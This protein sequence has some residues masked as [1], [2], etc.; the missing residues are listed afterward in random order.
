MTPEEIEE[1]INQ[2][3]AE[4][5]AAYEANR[6]TELADESQSQNRDDDDNENVKGNE[7]GNS[8]GNGD[9]NDGGNGNRNGGGNGNGNPNR[10]DRSVMP[11]AR[12]C[13]YHDFVKCQPLNFKGTEGVVELTRWFEKIETVFHIRNCPER[14]QVKYAT[15]TL[16]NSA[17]TWWNAH[18]R[19]IGANVAFSMSWRELMKLMTKR[20][21]ELTIMCTKMV[22]EEEDR[23]E[24]FI[25]G[26]PDNIQGN[27]IAVEPIRLQDVVCIANKLTD[28]KLKGYAVKNAKNK[29]RLDNN[30]KDNR[31]QQ[32]PYKRQNVGPCTV[33]C[34]K[35]N[36]VGHMARDCM[37][38]VA[39]TTTQRALVVNQRVPTCFECGRQGHYRNKCPKLKN[40]TCGNK[41]GKK[42]NEARGKAYVLGGG[43]ANPDSNVITSTFL[44]NNHYAS[45]LFDSGADRSFVSSTFSALLSVIPST[46]DVS[47]AVELADGRISET[48]TMLRGYTLGLLGHPFNIDLMPVELGSFDIIIGM[49]WLANHHVVIVCDEKIVRILYGDEVLIVQAPS[50]LQELSTQLQE[51]S[52]KGFIG[53]IKDWASPK[54]SMEIRQFL[55]LA[56]YY[57]RFIEGSENFMVYCDASH[58]GLG[59]VLIQRE[60][61]IAYASRQL[62]IHKKNYTTHDLELGVVVFALKMWRHYLHGTKILNAQAEVRKEENYVTKNLCRMIKKLEPS[63]EGTLCLRNRSWIPCYGDSRALIMHESHKSKYLIHPESN[64]MYQDLKNLYWWPN[65]KTEIATYVSTQ[66]DM[67]TANHLQTGGQSERTIQNLEDM[68]RACVNDFGR[69]WDRHLPLVE[70]RTTIVIKRV[71]KL[72]YSK[73]FTV[74]SVDHFSVGL[75]LEMLGNGY[76][77]KGQKESQKQQSQARDG[78]DKF[79]SKPKSVK[80]KSQP[81]EENT[82]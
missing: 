40:Q 21:Q 66:L 68:L 10:N 44:L 51:L 7:N 67:S 47:Y 52:D 12:E 57:R 81:S 29:R 53:L 71:S 23:F 22:P 1:H 24:K 60:K 56:G 73:N 19:K 55:G 58:K 33:K 25:G 42:T 39:A 5:L 30:H 11:V 62:K 46:L 13:T 27:V 8:G 74:V 75:R 34:G 36:K 79:K 65:M 6:V 4:A 38:V 31:V 2:R 43:E 32:P 35:C 26:L 48:N 82:T 41:A 69:S 77:R 17:L 16:L 45:M 49:D 72:H 78:K 9:G 15:C 76:S 63:A 14:Y 3:V 80:V 20:F 54:T 28:Q 50:E 64:K 59:A 70:F 37:N 61:V 18:K